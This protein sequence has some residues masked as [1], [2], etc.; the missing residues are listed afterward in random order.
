MDKLKVAW[1]YVKKYYFWVLFL[2][3]ILLILG[4]WQQTNSKLISILKKRSGEIDGQISQLRTLAGQQDPPNEQAIKYTRKRANTLRKS[5]VKAWHQLYQAQKKFNLWP[6]LGNSTS[7]NAFKNLGEKVDADGNYPEVPMAI[8]Q[9][10]RTRVP[11]YVNS[12]KIKYNIKRIKKNLPSDEKAAPNENITETKLVDL[13]T[14]PPESVEGVVFWNDKDF[15]MLLKRFIWNELP[16]TREIIVVQEDLWVYE[17]L[18]RIVEQTNKNA[19]DFN[20]P[21]KEIIGINVGR[22][23]VKPFT[24]AQERIISMTELF[25]KKGSE[26]GDDGGMGLAGGVSSL[27]DV[28]SAQDNE[29]K[30]LDKAALAALEYQR[31]YEYRYTNKN[32]RHLKAATFKENPPYI[33]FKILP[34]RMHLL[35]NQ[36]KVAQLLVHCANSSMPVEVLQVS[37]NPGSGEK[38]SMATA[39]EKD[40]ENIYNVDNPEGQFLRGNSLKRDSESLAN[41]GPEDVELEVLA[42]VYIF[43]YPDETKLPKIEGADDSENTESSEETIPEESASEETTSEATT[44]E[45]SA[46][47]SAA[48]GNA[49]NVSNESSSATTPSENTENSTDAQNKSAQTSSAEKSNSET[50]ESVKAENNEK[51]PAAPNNSGLKNNDTSVPPEPETSNPN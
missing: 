34:V 14:A 38:F 26:G 4:I 29:G 27:T 50:P 32:G 7:N 22:S 17:A 9:H 51:M 21:I 23:T 39:K 15:N 44:S 25:G 43:N 24:E 37:I 10:Y 36:R 40:R 48:P 8:R 30:D 33:E 46:D 3:G 45:E 20:A 12:L 19:T 11:E 31:L 49:E 2:I 28:A 18:L 5:V 47:P 35:M 1:R 13:R 6:D 41:R 16:S 42:L